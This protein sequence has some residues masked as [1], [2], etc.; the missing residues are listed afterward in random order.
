MGWKPPASDGPGI[1]IGA[2]SNSGWKPPASDIQ[3]V[4]GGG[5]PSPS[6]PKSLLDQ[7]PNEFAGQSVPSTSKENRPTRATGNQELLG[8]LMGAA[9]PLWNVVETI[10]IP[11]VQRFAAK[12]IRYIDQNAPELGRAVGEGI[13][14]AMPLG[15]VAEVG[16][17]AA[18]GGS[19]LLN[20]L[21]AA[22]E[23][24]GYGVAFSGSSNPDDITRNK[25]GGAAAGA[26]LGAGLS[27]LSHVP[28]I[29]GKLKYVTG[30]KA[31]EEAQ[32]LGS[33]IKQTIS[34]FTD[35]T[36]PEYSERAKAIA[37]KAKGQ[38]NRNVSQ[39]LMK[40]ENLQPEH[41]SATGSKITSDA[42]H[43]KE[44]LEANR[45]QRAQEAKNAAEEEA[46]QLESQG[47]F[48]SSTPEMK[49][50]IKH[51]RDLAS[52]AE[53]RDSDAALFYKKFLRRIE[54]QDKPATYQELDEARRWLGEQR[55][56]QAE[57]YKALQQRRINDLYNRYSDAMNKAFPKHGE[58]V[59]QYGEDSVDLDPF[60]QKLGRQMTARQSPW[61]EES[62][63]VVDPQ[64]VPSKAFAS[65]ESFRQT[66][67]LLNSK[68]KASLYARNYFAHQIQ[69][70]TADGVESFIKAN[71][72]V[73]EESGNLGKFQDYAAKLKRLES[74]QKD[75]ATLYDNAMRALGK[76]DAVAER[77][78][79]FQAQLENEKTPE[80][81]IRNA[82]IYSDSLLRDKI[83]DR[84]QYDKIQ[85]DIN[86]AEASAKTT[87]E[88]RK[89]V[90]GAIGTPLAL[91]VIHRL[92]WDWL[93]KLL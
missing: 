41:P 90:G 51:V 80:G 28:S 85:S 68:D 42:E 20:A 32:K 35:K 61:D 18:E 88:A 23:G 54:D 77:Y 46:A 75:R 93:S 70:K 14:Y 79:I 15:R 26:V 62:A 64:N 33:D 83:I 72:G 92:Q 24:A 81:I 57:G 17:A 8:V 38:A 47:K 50:L 30:K 34:E 19:A 39:D 60:K 56:P 5:A 59:R 44:K 43:I 67:K 58:F 29:M 65:P 45:R 37:A 11:P 13:M 53:K 78:R 52:Q 3:I 16:N 21:R 71:R 63:K 12:N 40:R 74:W 25:L 69:G 73:L 2:L 36:A 91:Y 55:D 27:G 49:A 10:P 87:K 82:R 76:K 4:K 6:R 22:G 86:R 66:V 48:A 31:A 84:E 9:K 1:P 7:I 89:L